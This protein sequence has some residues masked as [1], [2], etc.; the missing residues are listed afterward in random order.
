[1]FILFSALISVSFSQSNASKSAVSNPG[2]KL[3]TMAFGSCFKHRIIAVPGSEVI[4]DAVRSQNPDSW[5][6][7]GDFAY[8]DKLTPV[9]FKLNPLDEVK[10]RLEESYNDPCKFYCRKISF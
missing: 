5:V 1:M 4:F 7:L 6:W 10:R 9:G 8:L 2:K 3:H